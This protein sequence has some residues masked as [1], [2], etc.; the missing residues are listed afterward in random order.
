MPK[1]QSGKEE[2]MF[3]AVCILIPGLILLSSAVASLINSF[4][5]EPAR[6]PKP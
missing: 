1:P 2:K 6:I 4:K 3:W 5:E